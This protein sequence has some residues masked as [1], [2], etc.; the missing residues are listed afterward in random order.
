MLLGVLCVIIFRPFFRRVI[1]A[2]K[3]G[4]NGFSYL[5]RKFSCFFAK[6]FL[7][8]DLQD[9]TPCKCCIS[10]TVSA[11]GGQRMGR[12]LFSHAKQKTPRRC[13]VS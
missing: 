11:Q 13:G 6:K 12:G 1:A 10:P 8:A 7:S 5:F 9:Q 3:S 2:E 4:Y